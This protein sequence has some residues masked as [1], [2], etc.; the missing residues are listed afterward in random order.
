[1]CGIFAL[2]NNE[3]EIP[4]KNNFINDQFTKGKNRGPEFSK[5]IPYNIKCMIGFHRLAING[6][7][8]QSNQ[9][10]IIGDIALICNGEIYNYKEIYGYLEK[11]SKISCSNAR[12]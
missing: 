5:L 1:M 12:L 3:N 10:I 6:L 2:L 8:N 9:P 7:N 11:C 4:F